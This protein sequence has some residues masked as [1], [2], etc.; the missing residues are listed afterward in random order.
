MCVCVCVYVCVCVCV[1]VCVV[2]CEYVC[3][4]VCL[5]GWVD[6]VQ[7]DTYLDMYGNNGI[8]IHMSTAFLNELNFYRVLLF[9]KSKLK[10]LFLLL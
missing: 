8:Y 4:S 1:C 3:V 9:T 10:I 6:Y 7:Q 5:W 2:E